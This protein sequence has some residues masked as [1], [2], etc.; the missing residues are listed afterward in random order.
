MWCVAAAAWRVLAVLNVSRA[1][2]YNLLGQG[3]LV[4]IVIVIIIMLMN[5]HDDYDAV[6]VLCWKMTQWRFIN[7]FSSRHWYYNISRYATEKVPCSKYAGQQNESNGNL[8]DD[9]D[10]DDNDDGDIVNDTR[11]IV[12]AGCVW[13]GRGPNCGELEVATL[14][15]IIAGWNI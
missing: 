1:L 3:L 12:G 7:F 15:G 4:V 11:Q 13:A 10:G 14:P 5:N 9:D 2:V 6:M 8:D